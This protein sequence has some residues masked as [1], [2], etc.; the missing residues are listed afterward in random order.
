[1]LRGFLYW[2]TTCPRPLSRNLPP[3]PLPPL[4]PPPLPPLGVFSLLAIALVSCAIWS[5][6]VL[7]CTAIASDTVEV[8][9]AGCAA[10]VLRIDF[11]VFYEPFKIQLGFVKIVLDCDVL[12]FPLCH[13]FFVEVVGRVHL[14]EVKL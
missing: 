10:A 4:P 6:M 7:I 11:V 5:D 12:V 9:L 14:L 1:M 2:I 8:V 3:P 13:F